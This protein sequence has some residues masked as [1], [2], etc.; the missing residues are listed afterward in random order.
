MASSLLV[1]VG[2]TFQHA[3][4]LCSSVL[5]QEDNKLKKHFFNK[6]KKQKKKNKKKKEDP[7][8]YSFELLWGYPQLSGLGNC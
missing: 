4:W 3:F 2:G 6:T 1:K 7:I 5:S 8:F